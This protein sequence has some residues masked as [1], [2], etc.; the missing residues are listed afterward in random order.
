MF[1]EVDTSE[2]P[3]LW[4]TYENEIVERVIELT[5]ELG[6]LQKWALSVLLDR[7]IVDCEEVNISTDTNITDGWI[8][9]HEKYA[10]NLGGYAG[11]ESEKHTQWKIYAAEHLLDEAHNL[12]LYWNPG[13]EKRYVHGSVEQKVPFGFADIRCPEC[14]LAVEVGTVQANRCTSPF[15]MLIPTEAVSLDSN[16]LYYNPNLVL[17]SGVLII[18]YQNNPEEYPVTGYKFS[19]SSDPL[20]YDDIVKLS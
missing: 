10:P 12:T 11:S 14:G 3:P 5:S 15:G 4:P 7:G 9:A 20:E 18:P 13:G 2:L 1:E 16:K 19:L 8:E 6:I 17:D